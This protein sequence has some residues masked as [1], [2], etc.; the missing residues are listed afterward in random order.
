M[1]FERLILQDAKSINILTGFLT[2]NKSNHKLT[3]AIVHVWHCMHY[4]KKR[5][6]DPF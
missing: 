5:Y 4:L 2:S 6:F 1:N 3:V